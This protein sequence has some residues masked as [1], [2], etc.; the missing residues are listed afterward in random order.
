MGP[1]HW[2]LLLP[3]VYT[4][5]H[6]AAG[7]SA[8]EYAFLPCCF[9]LFTTLPGLPPFISEITIQ[10]PLWSSLAEYLRSALVEIQII[11]GSL[12][13]IQTLQ[14]TLSFLLLAC[15]PHSIRDAVLS[16]LYKLIAGHLPA[17]MAISSH[18]NISRMSAREGV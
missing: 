6:A 8:A 10:T 16:V 3:R 2:R 12:V 9:V 11:E 13:E 17:G 7:Q 14:E 4:S 1:V 5:P 15:L 18:K